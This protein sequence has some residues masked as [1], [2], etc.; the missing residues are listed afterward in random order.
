MLNKT[1]IKV[2]PGQAV[3]LERK[4]EFHRL[5]FEGKHVVNPFSDDVKMWRGEKYFNLNETHSTQVEETGQTK[6]PVPV[7]VGVSITFKITSPRDVVYLQGD[8]FP[9]GVK[10]ALKDVIKERLSEVSIRDLCESKSCLED[11]LVLADE[12]CKKQKAGCTPLTLVVTTVRSSGEHS[13]RL[14]PLLS[15]IWK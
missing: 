14:D 7:T 4:G 8:N 10:K 5:L 9:S 15:K 6:D 3:I 2:P 1:L 11:L 12:E 13:E